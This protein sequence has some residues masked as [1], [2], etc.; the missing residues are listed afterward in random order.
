MKRRDFIRAAAAVTA[1]SLA[2]RNAFAAESMT[3]YK[4]PNCGCCHAWTKAMQNAGYAVEI[5]DID[6]L[7]EI[8]Q[9]YGIS[10]ELQGCHT[11]VMAGYFIEG[12]VPLESVNWLLTERPE[13]AGL[14]VP[15]MPSGSL[16]M[17]DDPSASYD[18]LAVDRAGKATLHLAVRPT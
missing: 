2:T 10:A 8:K 4:D 7:S 16:G 9:K 17:G 15:G 5:H 18:V 1:V 14:A 6:D 12:H 13:I 3:I 11:A